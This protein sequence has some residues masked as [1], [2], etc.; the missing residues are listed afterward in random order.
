MLI[1]L[2]NNQALIE[3]VLV[4]TK[5]KYLQYGDKYLQC[6]SSR[7]LTSLDGLVKLF[8]QHG[9]GK[10]YFFTSLDSDF[11]STMT[12]PSL[13]PAS[14]DASNQTQMITIYCIPLWGTQRIF[15]HALPSDDLNGLASCNYK[16]SHILGKQMFST[17][18]FKILKLHKRQVI[19]RQ[20][21]LPHG[22]I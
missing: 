3:S 14:H 4:P 17:K 5:E 22:I 13:H 1:I 2:R 11:D 16:S 9:F 8:P 7:C 21:W 6:T 10:G 19:L 20:T 12:H 18:K 15:L